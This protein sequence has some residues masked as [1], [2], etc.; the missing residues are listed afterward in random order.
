MRKKV[1][2]FYKAWSTVVRPAISHDDMSRHF[3]ENVCIREK[4]DVISEN[5]LVLLWDEMENGSV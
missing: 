3:P 2:A 4:V 1:H 5:N